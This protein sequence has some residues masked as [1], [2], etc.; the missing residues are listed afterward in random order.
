MPD[1]SRDVDIDPAPG[2]SR[3]LRGYRATPLG[4]GP[5]PGVVVIHE[6]FG[7]TDVV[8]RQADRLAGAGYLALAP[9]LYTEGGALRC[10]VSTMRALSA[11]VGRPLIDIDAARRHL[12]ADADC[13]GRI[14]VIGFC[15]GGGF[16]LLMAGGDSGF[17]VSSVNYG[18]LPKDP[19]ATLRGG[20]PVVASYGKRDVSLRGAAATLDGVL[21]ELGTEH[22]VKEYPGAGHS[23]LNDEYFGPGLLHPIQRVGGVGP[24][25][26]AAADAWA[27]I[28]TFFARHLSPAGEA[29]G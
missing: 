19:E 9:D 23:F 7:L 24:D 25:P 15:M 13:S 5:W 14:G 18:Q 8:R 17:D 3:R 11:G 10:I 29:S 21:T 27:R 2:G 1:V 6:L 20:C 4:H 16:A 28:E 12:L 22:D 26:L